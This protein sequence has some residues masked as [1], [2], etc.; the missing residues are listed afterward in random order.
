MTLIAFLYATFFQ[1]PASDITAMAWID[2]A[3]DM[4]LSNLHVMQGWAGWIALVAFIIILIVVVIGILRGK[5]LLGSCAISGCLMQL[6]V[7][8]IFIWLLGF[9]H[10]WVVAFI[11]AH[12]TVLGPT[13][14]GIWIIIAIMLL[15][16]WS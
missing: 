10:I 15:C 6:C 8:A 2:K 5:D 11:A 1:M 13:N 14:P 12:F 16:S 9:V 7:A 3:I 4:T